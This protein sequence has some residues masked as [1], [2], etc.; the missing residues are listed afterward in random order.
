MSWTTLF[1]SPSDALAVITVAGSIL[2]V[3]GVM[4]YATWRIVR[5]G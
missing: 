3:F 5:H 4:G 2:V 1:E